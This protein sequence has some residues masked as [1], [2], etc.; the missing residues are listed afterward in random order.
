LEAKASAKFFKAQQLKASALLTAQEAR[1][2]VA[3]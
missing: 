3:R 2:R 1:Q